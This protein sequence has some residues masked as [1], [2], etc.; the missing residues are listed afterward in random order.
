MHG[1]AR[2]SQ[3][4]DEELGQLRLEARA[5][6]DLVQRG[7]LALARGPVLVD[8]VGDTSLLEGLC[9]RAE[10]LEGADFVEKRRRV[11]RGYRGQTTPCA[12]RVTRRIPL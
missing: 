2:F 12:P 10:T 9:W 5:I 6:R 1:G 7:R 8:E 3:S 11:R 4:R